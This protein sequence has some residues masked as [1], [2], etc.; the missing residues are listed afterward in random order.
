MTR[1]NWI[2][3]LKISFQNRLGKAR[4]IIWNVVKNNLTIKELSTNA[5]GG[6]VSSSG[7]YNIGK[8]KKKAGKFYFLFNDISL[9]NITD[10]IPGT[11]GYISGRI[12]GIVSL[13][14]K[15]KRTSTL[16]GLFNFW[17]VGSRKEKRIVGKAFLERLGAR[18]RLLLGSSKNYDKGRL[19]G[20]I[21]N[22]VITF[23]ELEISNSTL[24]LKD[25]NIRVH[26]SR[27][28]ISVAH[29]MSV[30]R[31]TARRASTGS[32]DLQFQN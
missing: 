12:P 32:L 19:Y 22:G 23:N 9:K 10:S 26:N 3:Q 30:I 6:K 25:L 16:D 27:N 31:E 20:Y 24:G 18:E 28:S 5:F 11:A 2:Y 29:L 8:T 14:Q 7:V 1:K 15:E 21:N 17:T 13:V 4:F